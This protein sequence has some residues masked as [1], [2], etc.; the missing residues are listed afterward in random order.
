M[1]ERDKH[2]RKALLLTVFLAAEAS[3][4][5]TPMPMV[6]PA[7]GK[8]GEFYHF[9]EGVCVHAT[10]LSGSGREMKSRIEE[11]K[12]TGKSTQP[13]KVI[14]KKIKGE[15]PICTRYK[16]RLEKYLKDGIDGINPLTGR[17]E[18]MK[19]EVARST[20]QDTRETVEILC[21]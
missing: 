5:D 19:G 12:K 13:K 15:D 9:I 7:D 3:F 4:A 8:C 21:K 16:A 11:F 20:I 2:M 10:S 1:I 6:L 14:E 18:K 17:I